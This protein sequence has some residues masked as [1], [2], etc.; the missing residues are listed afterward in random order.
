MIIPVL[1]ERHE[2]GSSTIFRVFTIDSSRRKGYICLVYNQPIAKPQPSEN[3]LTNRALASLSLS[4]VTQAAFGGGG[5]KIKT[6][7]ATDTRLKALSEA[8]SFDRPP[9]C[10][11][12]ISPPPEGFYLYYGGRNPK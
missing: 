9:F 2:L 10:S 12:T 4:G 8:L 11:G 3:L 5:G 6:S 7:M 1:S